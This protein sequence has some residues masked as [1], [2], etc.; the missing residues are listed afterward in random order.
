ASQ[1]VGPEGHVIGVD[2]ND[3][4]LQLARR[5]QSQIGDDIGWHNTIFHK[6][7][8]QDLALDLDQFESYL[9]ENPVHSSDDWM[10]AQTWSDQQRTTNPM[11]AD[12][13]VDVVV[14]N[15]VLNLVSPQAR[16]QL[17]AELFRV[18]KRG[19]RAVISDIVSDELVPEHLQNDPQLWSGCISGAFVED[20]FLSAFEQ[21]GFY[22]TEIIAR[23][24][25]P[26]A[27]IEGIEFRSMTV[28]AY[29]GKEGSCLD[30]HQAVIY[31]GPWK[32]VTDDD[33]HLLRRGER[34]SVCEKI[35]QIYTQQPYSGQITGIP[36]H[37]AVP[38]SEA[39]PY[40]CRDG[41]V[42]DPQQTKGKS[43]S[44]TTLPDGNC[45]GP[46]EGCC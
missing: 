17:F 12:S 42:R 34:M 7:R 40:D 24:Q 5:F 27:T 44:L 45:C 23:Q 11:I 46:D 28:R 43:V 39:Q 8:I 6:G 19:G 3:S 13:S 31:N 20:K 15:C 9:A 38:P 41:K 29:K 10:R 35:Y 1:V 36:P 22:G 16:Q 2:Q 33:G 32:S 18:L 37:E 26:W 14:S 21:A 4:M 30:H 25:Q